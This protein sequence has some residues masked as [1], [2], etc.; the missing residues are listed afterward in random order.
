MP[1]LSA[2]QDAAFGQFTTD[3]ATAQPTVTIA[4]D[5]IDFEPPN[6]GSYVLLSL[7]PGDEYAASVPARRRR[8]QGIFFV[9]IFTPAALGANPGLEIADSVLAVMSGVTVASVRF[10]GV[11]RPERIGVDGR[12]FQ[13]NIAMPF[14]TDTIT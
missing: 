11:R 2:I 7:V 1:D 13:H 14:E 6:S 9:Q 8:Q 12:W 4:Y 3:F 5:G 10:R